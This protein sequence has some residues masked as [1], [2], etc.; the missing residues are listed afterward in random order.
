MRNARRRTV[1]QVVPT[2]GVEGSSLSVG[3]DLAR[4]VFYA[5]VLKMLWYW[6]CILVPW[7]RPIIEEHPGPP[8]IL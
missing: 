7:K 5:C 6:V 1:T 3:F 4:T 2:E 8:L